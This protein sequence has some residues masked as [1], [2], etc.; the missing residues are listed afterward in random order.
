MPKSDGV[1]FAATY[2][3]ASAGADVG[4]DFYDV[5]EIADGQ[6]LVSIGDVCGKGARAAARTG[7]VRDVLR[8]LVRDGRPSARAF[9]QLNEMMLES[10]DPE[11][12]A[13]VALALIS[14]QPVDGRP[15][16]AVELVLAGHDQPVL[17][18]ADGT[19]RMVGRHGT[20]AGLIGDFAVYPTR[21]LLGPGDALVSYTDG[22]TERRRGDEQFGQARLVRTLAAAA[23]GTAESLV[24]A[25][26]RA[27]DGFSS[28]PQRDDIVVMVVRAPDH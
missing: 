21:H 12:F 9:E 10:H 27:V 13:T 2:V 20:A 7:L 11:Q 28:E 23:G 6:W 4:G 26:W 14:R 18:C 8:V 16:L 22:I 5:M 1:E 17:V 3:P 19:A 25:V 15:G 24:A